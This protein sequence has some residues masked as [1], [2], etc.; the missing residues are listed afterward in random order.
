MQTALDA[1]IAGEGRYRPIHSAVKLPVGSIPDCN[2]DLYIHD[3]PCV[4]LVFT[5]NTSAAV[6]VRWRC[7]SPTVAAAG[8]GSCRSSGRRG[9][10]PQHAAAGAGAAAGAPAPAR[11]THTTHGAT[12]H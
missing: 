2:A 11:K 7:S 5:P 4:T 8:S 10:G 1:S 6:Q 3:K 9:S 12:K